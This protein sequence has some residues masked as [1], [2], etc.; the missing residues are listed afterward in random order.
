MYIET[1]FA[2]GAAA[3]GYAYQTVVT[4][5][6]YDGTP[7]CSLLMLSLSDHVAVRSTLLYDISRDVVQA[8]YYKSKLVHGKVPPTQACDLLSEWISDPTFI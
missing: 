6:P 3:D 8:E 7:V 4:P 1:F 2:E 5:D